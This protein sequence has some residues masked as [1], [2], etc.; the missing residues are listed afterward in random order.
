MDLY[1]QKIMDHYLHPKHQGK[2]A[3]ADKKFTGQNISCG[4]VVD[5][6]IKLDGRDKIKQ[7][8]W[9]GSGCTISQASASILSDMMIGK[10]I[11]QVQSI[12]SDKFLKDLEV[13]L[14]PARRKCALLALYTVKEEEME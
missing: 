1:Q 13:E 3:K 8:A 6:Q 10:T 5:F 11:K 14:S 2:L 4:D 9:Q 12:S 7:V